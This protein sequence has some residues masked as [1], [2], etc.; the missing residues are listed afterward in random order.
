MS[1]LFAP[2][3]PIYSML[4]PHPFLYSQSSHPTQCSNGKKATSLPTIFSTM[5]IAVSPQ[6]VATDDPSQSR[7]NAVYAYWIYPPGRMRNPPVRRHCGVING[8]CFAESM[9]NKAFVFYKWFGGIEMRLTS[10]T[11]AANVNEKMIF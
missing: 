8:D 1:R 10:K 9:R 7:P 2:F 6:P 4:S 5:D 3:V 11:A